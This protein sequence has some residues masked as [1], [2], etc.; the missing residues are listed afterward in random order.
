MRA[1]AAT[2]LEFGMYAASFLAP[3]SFICC[4]VGCGRHRMTPYFLPLKRGTGMARSRDNFLGDCDPRDRDAYVKLF[5]EI[6]ALARR[7][8]DPSPQDA[9]ALAMPL[10]GVPL[11]L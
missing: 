7:L 2:G 3:S 9:D 11:R 6:E 8:G 5:D 4:C 1:G 10:D